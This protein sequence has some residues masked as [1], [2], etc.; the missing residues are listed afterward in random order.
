MKRTLFTLALTAI[1]L[2]AA[3]TPALAA[4]AKTISYLNFYWAQAEIEA[5]EA[6]MPGLAEL[7]RIAAETVEKIPI[8]IGDDPE[9]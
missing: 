4:S 7:E 6:G 3:I 5:A 8:R 9:F 2:C 1:V